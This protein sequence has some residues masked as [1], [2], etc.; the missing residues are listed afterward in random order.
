[1]HQHSRQES[2]QQPHVKK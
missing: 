1:M 2:G